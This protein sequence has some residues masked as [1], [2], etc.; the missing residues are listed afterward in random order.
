MKNLKTTTIITLIYLLLMNTSFVM[1]QTGGRI[2]D[3]CEYSIKADYQSNNKLIASEL[4]SHQGDI[5]QYGIDNPS[6][7]SYLVYV[8]PNGTR[9][10][11]M[12]VDFYSASGQKPTFAVK[13]NQGIE[14]QF[15]EGAANGYPSVT[16]LGGKCSRMV[17]KNTII[18]TDA[19]SA[20]L[21]LGPQSD[22]EFMRIIIDY[23]TGFVQ[24]DYNVNTNFNRLQKLKAKVASGKNIT[25]GVIGGSIT[26]G[27]NAEPMISNSYSGRI[28][29][30]F[31]TKYGIAVNLVNAGIGST[32]SYFG[33]IR[34][35]EHVLKN[36]PDLVI[37]DY[38]VNDGYEQLYQQTYEGLLRKILKS[39]QH[40]ALVTAMFCTQAGIS[41]QALKAPIA[42]RYNVPIISYNDTIKNNI[43]SGKKT[44]LDYYK[45]TTTPGGDGV[46]PNTYAHQKTADLFALV[47]DQIVANQNATITTIMPA[48]LYNADFE[49]AFFLSNTDIIPVK[50]GTWID[51]GSI[52]DFKTGKGWRSS[53]AG[54]E[55]TFSITGDVAAVTY[56]RRPETEQYGRAEVWVDNKPSTI[57]DGSNGGALDQYVL[58]GLG[59]GNHQLHIKLLDNKAFEVVCIAVSGDRSF[60]NSSK[61]LQ[62][63]ANAQYVSI[64]AGQVS[65][66]T[67]G[68]NNML[69]QRDAEGYLE[70]SMNGQRLS[71]DTSNSSYKLIGSATVLGDK[72]KYLFVDKGG[73]FALRSVETGLYISLKQVG[74]T[75]GLYA[76]SPNVSDNELF[77]LKDSQANVISSVSEELATPWLGYGYNQ[78]AYSRQSDGNSFKPWDDI[79]WQATKNRILAINPGM[80]RMPVA[81]EWFTK[82][83]Q[84]VD[85]PI[86]TYNWNNKYMLSFYKIM[87]LYKENNILV[88]CGLWSAGEGT[89]EAFWISS[90]NNSFARLQGDFINHLVN[91]KGYTNIYYTPV[92]EP[93][94]Y[95]SSY[96][97]WDKVITNLYNELKQR[98]LP[99]NILVGADGWDEYVWMPA[100]NNKSQ[101][102]AYEYHNYLNNT[103]TDSY[104]SLYT[105]GIEQFLIDERTLVSNEDNSN[106]PLFIGE[107]API[108]AGPVDYPQPDVPA[109]GQQ[110]TYE[111]GL[112]YWDYGI[113]LAR[114]G[115]AGALAWALDG[116]DQNKN[117]G[118]WNNSGNFGGM[119]LRPWY[120]TWQLMCR[121]FPKGSKILK[122]TELNGAK[123]L[124]IVGAR[125]NQNDY[126]FTVVNRNVN[127]S[128]GT[129]TITLKA[130]GA[131]KTF[132]VYYYNTNNKGDGT[133]L[134]LPYVVQNTTDIASSGIT[135]TV[136]VETGVLLTTLPPTPLAFLG[137]EEHQLV[138]SKISL[139]PN[140]A[141]DLF[142][143]K[144]LTIGDKIIINDLLGK[145][146]VNTTAKQENEVISTAGFT[147]GLYIVWVGGKTRLKLVK[148]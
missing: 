56:W 144:G 132:Y 33:A 88:Q 107:M 28:K 53:Q 109:F 146:I 40:P 54:S 45:T 139:F 104:N 17:L 145:T 117:A 25:I 127:A 42:Q 23:G 6:I 71:V 92:N 49:D 46:H 30:Y 5:Y 50:T 126:T 87:D 75:Y 97:V 9:V 29:N 101:L 121:Y 82:D 134:S 60:F 142:T 133:S 67:N 35:E 147:A 16:S 115:T 38:C 1:A 78:C 79:T 122:M 95:Y 83:D 47:F 14:T 72:S 136:P 148:E 100:R 85:L 4:V 74:Q 128:S 21:Y 96:A 131:A 99:T 91:T 24:P 27:A 37:V 120:Y 10:K 48:P 110:D 57:I 41:A 93:R 58:S 94:G 65:L 61:L 26:A 69:I 31:E 20:V 103:P 51:G 111:Y 55:L 80:V 44:W 3:E 34:A 143:L 102:V 64:A 70:L 8:M 140:P 114:S 119:T 18:P 90:G 116:F 52:F 86:G 36:N 11:S 59:N 124:R 7:Y 138:N 15:L 43:I 19:T 63:K 89:N 77:S 39:P 68:N 141:K 73:Y 125:I 113:Q 81:R 129:Q 118:M 98:N 62:S 130:P 12:T 32:N 84:G 2:Y 13:N 106:K 112:G 22:V 66:S 135:I 123:D 105:R 108:G 137:I 76:S